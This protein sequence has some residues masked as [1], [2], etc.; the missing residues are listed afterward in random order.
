MAGFGS[1]Y[2]SDQGQ[3]PGAGQGASSAGV[4][5]A[6]ADILMKRAQ[7][8]TY[9]WQNLDD[10]MWLM[11]HFPN[12]YGWNS[13]GGGGGGYE[14]GAN[15]PIMAAAGGGGGSSEQSDWGLK[16]KPTTYS[17]P[18]NFSWDKP[19]TAQDLGSTY[20]SQGGGSI[21]SSFDKYQYDRLGLGSVGNLGSSG[22]WGSTSTGNSFRLLG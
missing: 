3:S 7:D 11:R 17:Q 8:F 9:N 2:Q 1:G 10:R 13:Q 21:Q 18:Q 16:Q 20:G 4:Y 14:A 12:F 5:G 15:A 22:S 19:L 6:I